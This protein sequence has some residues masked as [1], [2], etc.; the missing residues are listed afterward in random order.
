ML[1]VFLVSFSN[2]PSCSSGRNGFHAGAEEGLTAEN[3]S[4]FLAM[5]KHDHVAVVI[6]V[7][8]RAVPI[9]CHVD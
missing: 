8:L 4:I 1:Q 2:F 6:S 9:L 5:G 3:V 7:I